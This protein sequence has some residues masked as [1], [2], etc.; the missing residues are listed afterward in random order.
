M[1]IIKGF[2][3]TVIALCVFVVPA[4]PRSDP[5]Q[6]CLNDAQNQYYVDLTVCEWLYE[7]TALANCNIRAENTQ[8]RQ[9][10][11]CVALYS[12]AETADVKVQQ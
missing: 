1:K 10:G 2:V 7:G 6:D 9:I 8:T 4:I 11:I 12:L 5:F 3:L